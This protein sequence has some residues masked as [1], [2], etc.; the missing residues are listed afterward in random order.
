MISAIMISAFGRGSTPPVPDVETKFRTLRLFAVIQIIVGIVL[1]AAAGLVLLMLIGVI[2]RIDDQV[3]SFVAG[4]TGIIV[5]A[6]LGISG[7]ASIAYGQ[8]LQVV[9]QIEENTRK[10]GDEELASDGLDGCVSSKRFQILRQPKDQ[11]QNHRRQ[12]A[13]FSAPLMPLKPG[14]PHSV[15]NPNEVS[16]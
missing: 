11:G 2:P 7:T 5:I 13:P 1:L 8:F 12:I 14:T 3:A 9:M 16:C 15:A 4:V 10:G 6:V